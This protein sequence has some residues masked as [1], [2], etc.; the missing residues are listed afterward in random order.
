LKCCFKP[1][2]HG[3]VAWIPEFGV[4][5]VADKIKKGR[6]LGIADSFGVGFVAFGETVQIG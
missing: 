5:I 1:S 2:N 6:E 3:P 4:D